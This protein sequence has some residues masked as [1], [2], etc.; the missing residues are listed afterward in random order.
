MPSRSQHDRGGQ[1][2]D[3]PFVGKELW[4]EG[5]QGAKHVVECADHDDRADDPSDQQVAP[6]PLDFLFPRLAL[7]I[8]RVRAFAALEGLVAN[9]AHGSFHSCRGHHAGDVD[10]PRGPQPQVDDCAHHPW[11]FHQRLF[12][13]RHAGSGCFV[14]RLRRRNTCH[15]A[16]LQGHLG[17]GHLVANSVDGVLHRRDVDPLRFIGQAG[18]VGRQ[19]DQHV[20]DARQV[21]QRFLD[22]RH[23]GSAGHACDR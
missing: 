23:A 13:L 12:Y 17:G 19:V 1:Q 15:A 14:R 6:L 20:C 2:A 22:V 4:D 16:H 8:Q 3:H 21:L 11:E 18:F 7:A 5:L 10:D 9:V